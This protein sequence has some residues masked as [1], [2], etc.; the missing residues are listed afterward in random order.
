M[1]DLLTA[2]AEF[3]EE[4]TKPDPELIAQLAKDLTNQMEREDSFRA[5]LTSEPG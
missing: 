5:S 1:S 4:I 2:F 3:I